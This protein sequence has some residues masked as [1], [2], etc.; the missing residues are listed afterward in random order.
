MAFILTPFQSFS[1]HKKNKKYK[2][3]KGG[4]V[5]TK[6]NHSANKTDITKKKT[7]Q[8]KTVNQYSRTN[9]VVVKTR[10]Y[11]TCNSLPYGYKGFRH[12]GYNYFHH[13]G[14]C[15]GYYNNAYRIKPFPIGFRVN[16]LPV[17][18]HTIFYQGST[19]YYYGG[20]YYVS[21]NN[22]YKTEAPSMGMIVPNL[23][24]EDLEEVKMNDTTYYEYN[25]ILYKAIEKDGVAQYEVVGSLVD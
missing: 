1:Q 16:V 13:A 6:R 20:T 8:Y 2:V 11:R 3:S 17:G 18:Y 9:V 19:R 22:S 24:E 15:Y 7:V 23:P 21:E 4:N 14:F 10:T 5:H 25:D 12:S